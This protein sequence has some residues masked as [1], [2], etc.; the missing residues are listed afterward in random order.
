MRFDNKDNYPP[1]YK[2]VFI[3]YLPYG[4]D[5]YIIDRAWLAEN[6]NGE[7]IWTLEDDNIC[8]GDEQVINWTN[9]E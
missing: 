6:D 9:Y 4:G 2:L 1:Y 3:E 5:R 8:I 7:Y